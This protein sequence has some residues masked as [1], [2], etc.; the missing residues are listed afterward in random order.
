M[1]YTINISIPKKLGDLAKA[2]VE[3]GYYS[4]VSE[5]VRTA[6]RTLLARESIPL[7]T[8]SS[9]RNAKMDQDFQTKKNIQS[10]NSIQELVNQ[11]HQ[12]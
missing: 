7:S 4:S 2:Q 6:M 10:A 8:K 12:D 9:N 11:L 1:N 3:A 5:V